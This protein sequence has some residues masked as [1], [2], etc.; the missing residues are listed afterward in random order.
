MRHDDFPIRDRAFALGDVPE[1]WHPA[2]RAVTRY[3]DNLSLFFPHGEAFFIRSVKAFVDRVDDPALRDAVRRFYGQEAFHG[4]EHRRYNAMLRSQGLPVDAMEDRVGALLRVVGRRLPR[5]WQLAATCALEHFT[6]I[7]AHELLGDPRVLDGAHPEM[8]SLWR[9]HAVEEAE[10]KAVAFD[11]YRAA[12]GNTA[13]RNLIMV[14]TT[15]IFWA[16]VVEHQI[17]LMG[18]EGMLGSLD[19]W[20][21]LMRFLFV[22]PGN[23][24]RLVPGYLAWFRAD[25]H[26]E[27]IDTRPLI[28]AWRSAEA[29]A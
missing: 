26:P 9:W 29:A 12:G 15:V 20:R 22:D 14:A 17:R 24:K 16:K 10:H 6:S 23:M 2:G 4:R 3:F 25:F 28:E 8:A 1:T 27:Q 13:E 11:V 21:R 19:E 5:R 18:H 7:M